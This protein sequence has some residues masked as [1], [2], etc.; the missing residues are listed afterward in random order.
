MDPGVLHADSQRFTAVKTHG[1][2]HQLTNPK[3]DQHGSNL[4]DGYIE[5]GDLK[6]IFLTQ[7]MMVWIDVVSPFPR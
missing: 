3:M 4:K 5:N 2:H 6:T 7:Q 1:F